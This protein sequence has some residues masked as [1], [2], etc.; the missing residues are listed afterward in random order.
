MLAQCESCLHVRIPSVCVELDLRSSVAPSYEDV[1][2]RHVKVAR[3]L[4]RLIEP[5][6]ILP[7]PMERNGHNIVSFVEQFGPAH[8]HQACD[9]ASQ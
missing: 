3:Q 2:K 1:S 5:A 7:S 8:A 6:V 9:R 4:A